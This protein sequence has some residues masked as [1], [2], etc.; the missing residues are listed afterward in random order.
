LDMIELSED[1]RPLSSV[2]FTAIIWL[3]RK[4]FMSQMH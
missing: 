1:E 4:A 2:A 3:T